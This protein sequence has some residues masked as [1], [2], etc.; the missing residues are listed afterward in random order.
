MTTPASHPRERN[1][2]TLAGL[3]ALF[4]LPLAMAFFTYYGSGWR[5]A[6]RVNHG[7]LITPARRCCASFPP[8]GAR[9][10]CSWSIRSATS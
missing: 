10:R 4:L 9:I 7:L 1:L 6:R 8:R 5:P 2:R 3:A